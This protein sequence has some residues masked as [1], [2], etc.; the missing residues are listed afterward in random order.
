MRASQIAASMCEGEL[1]TWIADDGI[2]LPDSLDKNIDL[3]RSMGDNNK[4]VVVTKYYEGKNGTEKPLQ[5]DNY[6]KLNGSDWTSSPFISKEWW[7][8]NVAIIH[9]T[10]FEELGGWDSLYEGTFYSHADMAVRAQYL[11]ANVKMSDFPLLNCDHEQLDHAPIESAQIIHDKPL[12]QS[13]YRNPSWTMGEMRLDINN[14]KDSSAV[15]KRR[16]G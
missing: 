2:L 12:F 11:G 8:F 9:R 14:W 10:F 13:R 3:L 6:F 5:P 15:W 7:L 1:V 4:N 16:F